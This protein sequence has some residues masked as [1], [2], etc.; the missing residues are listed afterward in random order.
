MVKP[1]SSYRNSHAC[2]AI[3]RKWITLNSCHPDTRELM[4]FLIIDFLPIFIELRNV[5]VSSVCL[6]S[7]YLFSSE[8]KIAILLFTMLTTQKSFT[9]TLLVHDLAFVV[10]YIRSLI[11]FIDYYIRVWYSICCDQNKTEKNHIKSNRK[12]M[13]RM[14]INVNSVI[15]LTQIY[16]HTHFY[17][18]VEIKNLAIDTNSQHNSGKKI[19]IYSLVSLNKYFTLRHISTS[20]F[21]IWI[22]ISNI[23]SNSI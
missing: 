19:H 8:R 22:H 3:S 17:L 21:L 5:F 6:N 10:Q 20:H 15:Q 9:H 1:I 18:A 4:T 23:T 14:H 2:D 7:S 13:W 16:A 12:K 11:F